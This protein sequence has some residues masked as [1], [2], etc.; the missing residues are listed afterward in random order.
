MESLSNGTASILGWRN[1]TSQQCIPYPFFIMYAIASVSFEP[2]WE[3]KPVTLQA[4]NSEISFLQPWNST[5]LP[6]RVILGNW[7]IGCTK[8]MRPVRLRLAGNMNRIC[9]ANK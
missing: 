1:C 9:C 3:K 5:I 7:D 4:Q 6:A 2:D 8:Q